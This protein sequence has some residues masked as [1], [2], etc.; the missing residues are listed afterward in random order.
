[1]NELAEKQVRYLRDEL[2]VRLGNLASNLAHI[3]SFAKGGKNPVAVERLLGESRFFIE[4]TAAETEIET[5][6]ELVEMQVQLSWWYHHWKEEQ[7]KP[8]QLTKITQQ[9]RA[10][11]DRVLDLSGL[12]QA[13]G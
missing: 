11:S 6:A 1:M 12:L 3:S 10:W 4:W 13:A 2:P 9:A 8:L 7:T 5:A